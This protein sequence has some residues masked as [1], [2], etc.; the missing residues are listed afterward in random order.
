MKKEANIK[1]VSKMTILMEKVNLNCFI[2][3][4]DIKDIGL[5]IIYKAKERSFMRMGLIIK[6]IWQEEKSKSKVY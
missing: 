1:E 2:R 3:K 5:I 4:G 6:V